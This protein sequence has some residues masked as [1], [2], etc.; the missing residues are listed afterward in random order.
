MKAKVLPTLNKKS[1]RHH[2]TQHTQICPKKDTS[3]LNRKSEHHHPIQYTHIRLD[4]EFH[5][6]Q[7]IFTFWTKFAQKEYFQSKTEIVNI[8]IVFTI[9]E[10]DCLPNSILIF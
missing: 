9:L 10:I 7:I 5:L 4:N 3:I 1:E 8:T 6:K 2:R